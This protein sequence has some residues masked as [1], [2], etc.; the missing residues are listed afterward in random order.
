MMNRMSFPLFSSIL[1]TFGA[2]LAIWGVL[3]H[4]PRDII[5]S[6]YIWND[7]PGMITAIFDDT[8]IKNY[9]RHR[10]KSVLSLMIV[11]LGFVLSLP[12]FKDSSISI[13][14]LVIVVLLFFLLSVLVAGRTRKDVITSWQRNDCTIHWFIKLLDKSYYD[15]QHQKWIKAG[16]GNEHL[17]HVFGYFMH[18]KGGLDLDSC[19][20]VKDSSRPTEEELEL[21]RLALKKEV[22]NKNPFY[23][24]F[25]PIKLLRAFK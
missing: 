10:N 22:E 3:T 7:R 12:F 17:E 15:K 18:I 9:I 24:L 21:V 4:S 20:E 16:Q 14:S 25:R 19:F 11:S 23:Y 6:S 1:I 13:R 8:V 2:I 5:H